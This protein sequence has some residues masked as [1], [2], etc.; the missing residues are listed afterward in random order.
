L[1]TRR[2]FLLAAGISLLMAAAANSQAPDGEKLVKAG[3]CSGCHAVDSQVVGP[4]YNA[5]AK[6]YRG[7]A[8]AVEKLAARIRAGGSGKWGSV[9]MTPHA[10]LSDA[11]SRE[12]VKWIL[13]LKDP[14]AARPATE[15]KSYTYT[16]KDGKTA[17]LDFSLFADG[18]GPKVTKAVFRGYELYNS[19]CYRC[20]GTDAAGSQLAPD[21]RHSLSAGMTRQQFLSIAMA[22]KA[23]K[24]MPSWAGF[25]SREDIT[26]TYQYV[27]GRS[28]DLVPPGRP[29]SEV[30]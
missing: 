10:D 6:R 26:S 5:I 19:Y 11:Q 23:D 14:A 28:L 2:G 24:G 12:M 16:L 18:K 15:S 21:L 13:S 22:G 17:K 3:D 30:E 27:K 20:H 25:L 9:A 4:A 8:D 29:A 7:Q 1:S